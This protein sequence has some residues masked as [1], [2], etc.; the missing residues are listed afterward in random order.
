[1]ICQRI[2]PTRDRVTIWIQGV[3]FQNVVS[4]TLPCVLKT[5]SPTCGL[6][7]MCPF[8]IQTIVIKRF[9][10]LATVPQR[11]ILHLFSGTSL[12]FRNIPSLSGG[13]KSLPRTI[14]SVPLPGVPGVL[15]SRSA[16]I[17]GL[18]DPHGIISLVSPRQSPFILFLFRHITRW[19]DTLC[20]FPS[21]KPPMRLTLPLTSKNLSSIFYLKISFTYLF[22]NIYII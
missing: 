8:I 21:E 18:G 19:L 15:D 13:Q 22:F 3:I 14:T 4:S 16:I 6:W 11:Q 10:T 7:E 12:D 1:M 9:I 2:E 17:A 5:T 20:I